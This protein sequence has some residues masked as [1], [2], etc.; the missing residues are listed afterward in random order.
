MRAGPLVSY[1]FQFQVFVLEA[2]EKAVFAKQCSFWWKRTGLMIP[3]SLVDATAV[4]W[5]GSFWPKDAKGK[6]NGQGQCMWKWFDKYMLSCFSAR[7]GHS[8]QQF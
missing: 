6:F 5:S 2:S 8:G 4:A 7:S 3:P 1:H